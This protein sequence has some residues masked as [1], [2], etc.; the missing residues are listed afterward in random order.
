MG[1]PPLIYNYCLVFLFLIHGGLLHLQFHQRFID[2]A[3]LDGCW[4]FLGF[5]ALLGGDMQIALHAA[6]VTLVVVP[7]T[8]LVFF[9]VALTTGGVV[10]ILLLLKM[11]V[12]VVL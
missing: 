7:L 6:I 2:L 10:L 8:I 3:Y 1:I 11:P 12:R 5:F 4:R 9:L